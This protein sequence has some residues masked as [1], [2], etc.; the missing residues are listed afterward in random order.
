MAGDH[1]H[2][3]ADYRQARLR[4]VSTSDHVAPVADT[5]AGSDTKRNPFGIKVRAWRAQG[6]AGSDRCTVEFEVD[7]PSSIGLDINAFPG[8][9]NAIGDYLTNAAKSRARRIWDAVTS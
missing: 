3:R 5:A 4:A 9:E 6:S 8:I 1:E 2:R 7:M